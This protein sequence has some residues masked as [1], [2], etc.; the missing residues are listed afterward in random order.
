V[1]RKKFDGKLN[2]EG[3][4]CV[5]TGAGGGIGTDISKI[6]AKNGVKMAMIDKADSVNKLAE[7]IC[8]NGGEAFAV[9]DDITNKTAL[10]KIMN[11]TV[12][13]YGKIDILIN[14]AAIG[15][16]K[17]AE[18][19]TEKEWDDTFA[20][21][22]KPAFL[23]C[24][25]AALQM[26][27]QGT[28]GKIINIASQAATVA[29]HGHV[30]YSASKAAMIAMTKNMAHEW[31]KYGINVNTISPTVVATPL[32]LSFW[33]GERAKKA[34]EE[35]PIGRFGYTDEIAALCMF[36]SSDASDLITGADYMI[37][38]GYTIH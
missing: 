3:K 17:K 18:E 35:I 25:M 19:L 33:K 9:M 16:N 10:Q 12:K 8:A 20:V 2:V 7:D 36:L 14:G 38:G 13:R 28:G 23:L 15:P 29:I 37:D 32:A 26:M 21:N 11:E 31:G 24:Q 4:V 30:S 1:E 34:I 6:F 27:K 5:L 22:L